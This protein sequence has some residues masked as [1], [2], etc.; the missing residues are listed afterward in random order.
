MLCVVCSVCCVLSAV[1]CLVSCVLCVACCMLFV[2]VLYASVL[3][4]L[5]WLAICTKVLGEISMGSFWER[6]WLWQITCYMFCHDSHTIEQMVGE[7]AIIRTFAIVRRC[8]YTKSCANLLHSN[9]QKATTK[10][11]QMCP[12]ARTSVCWLWAGRVLRPPRPCSRAG[13]HTFWR[14]PKHRI[15][16]RVRMCLSCSTNHLK[17]WNDW[18]INR[19]T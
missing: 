15:T 9:E 13:V 7:Y 10:F 18:K 19:K 6:Q 2:Y 5:W 16:L 4:C 14:F 8:T 17:H 12:Q 3:G 1:W 11:L